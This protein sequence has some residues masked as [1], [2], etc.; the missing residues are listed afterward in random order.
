MTNLHF[1]NL[2]WVVTVTNLHFRTIKWCYSV[3]QYADNHYAHQA[4]VCQFIKFCLARWKPSRLLFQ[5]QSLTFLIFDACKSRKAKIILCNYQWNNKLLSTF[6]YFEMV[7]HELKLCIARTWK[8]HQISI[9]EKLP[10]LTHN[11][12]NLLL[13]LKYTRHHA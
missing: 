13:S 6:P 8:D 4:S 2:S 10:R 5:L 12:A 1:R 11:Q 3:S 7:S 9:N